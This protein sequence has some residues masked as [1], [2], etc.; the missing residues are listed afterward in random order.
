MT[1][2]VLEPSVE[3]SVF[4]LDHPADKPGMHTGYCANQRPVLLQMHLIR[5]FS[6]PENLI[7]KHWLDADVTA[8]I[9]QK[10]L[11]HFEDFR[12]KASDYC[13]AKAVPSA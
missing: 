10:N 4:L 5:R 12:R 8:K 13:L 9:W 6:Q 2:R 1:T 7:L 11:K 3:E